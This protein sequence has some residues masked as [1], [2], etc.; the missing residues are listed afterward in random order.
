MLSIFSLLR[1]RLRCWGQADK[2]MKASPQRM[3][4]PNDFYYFS[5]CMTMKISSVVFLL[6][7][8]SCLWYP[9]PIP[10]ST[11]STILETKSY[12]TENLKNEWELAGGEQEKLDLTLLS[13]Q[14]YTGTKDPCDVSASMAESRVEKGEDWQERI[15]HI[16]EPV[17]GVP[18]WWVHDLIFVF[19][20]VWEVF[21]HTEL[22]FTGEKKI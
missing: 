2:N 10:K 15:Q 1:S 14:S 21:R 16:I 12:C 22:C 8:Y 18:G 9:H 19:L 17:S 6:L 5:M 7:V 20:L 3:F 11:P 13:L 4:F